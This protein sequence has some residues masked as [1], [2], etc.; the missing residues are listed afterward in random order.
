MRESLE[1]RAHLIEERATALARTAIR[2]RAG[3]VQRTGW[4][5]TLYGHESVPR[6]LVALA[7]YREKYGITGS[8][9]L[10][11]ATDD[12]RQA[13]D[14]ET[15]RAAISKVRKTTQLAPPRPAHFVPTPS[16]GL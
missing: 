12:P 13:H 9:P 10:G 11:P 16:I 5:L 3:W 14:R 8:V 4:D 15:V 1:E 6:E 7:A 2:N